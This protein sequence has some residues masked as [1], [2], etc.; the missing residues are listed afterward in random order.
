[1]R[2]A[3]DNLYGELAVVLHKKPDEISSYIRERA[4]GSAEA[5]Q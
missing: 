3:K 4:G 2:I 1:M 5:A